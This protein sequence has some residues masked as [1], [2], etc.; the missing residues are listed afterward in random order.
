VVLD[1]ERTPVELEVGSV[2][3]G[4]DVKLVEETVVVVDAEEVPALPLPLTS[5][6]PDEVV[7][8]LGPHASTQ[9]R[10]TVLNSRM[11]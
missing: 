6:L 4:F 2:G 5:P 10:T 3:S 8:T 9:P 7:G 1:D 11:T